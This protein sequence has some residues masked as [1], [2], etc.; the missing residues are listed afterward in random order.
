MDRKKIGGEKM[1]DKNLNIRIEKKLADE[2]E[3]VTKEKAVN[4]SE[5]LRI[6]IRA[7]VEKLRG[8]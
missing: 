4:K 8:E 6:W 2:F 7:Y 5:I 3:R 1:K